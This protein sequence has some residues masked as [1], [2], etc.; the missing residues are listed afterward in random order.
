MVNVSGSEC[1]SRIPKPWMVSNVS[2]N[3]SHA[4][5][6]TGN[7]SSVPDE[8]LVKLEGSGDLVMCN[9]KESDDR[10]GT[11]QWAISG[12]ITLFNLS[13]FSFSCSYHEGQD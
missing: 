7:A 6:Y 10:N 11:W 9:L 8:W 12:A 1:V 13:V 3:V 4:Q 2:D 5:I